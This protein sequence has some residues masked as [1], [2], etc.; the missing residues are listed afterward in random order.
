MVRLAG[1]VIYI[2]EV[3]NLV[4]LCDLVSNL[5]LTMYVCTYASFNYVTYNSHNSK[6][7]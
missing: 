3:C 4:A 1:S 2:Y 7:V 6:N 5:Y